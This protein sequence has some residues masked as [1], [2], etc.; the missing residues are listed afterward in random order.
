MDKTF[1][2]SV[3]LFP[4]AHTDIVQREEAH[5]LWGFPTTVEDLGNLFASFC[6]GKLSS[7]PWS[8]EPPAAETSAIS[9]NLARL[10][11][12]GFLT[13]NSQ[14]AVNGL[15]SNDK[16]HGWGPSNGF[17]YQKVRISEQVHP[18]AADEVVGIPRVFCFSF[19]AYRSYSRDRT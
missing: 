6:R 10:N 12:L 5:K 9:E 2:E 18:Q 15:P 19:I 16:V 14:P 8:D 11:E 3:G 17:V 1:C 7:L 4:Q 13:I